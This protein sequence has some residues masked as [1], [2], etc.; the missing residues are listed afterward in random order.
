[1]AFAHAC[2]SNKEPVNYSMPKSVGLRSSLL[3]IESLLVPE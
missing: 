3:I 2:T 1:M